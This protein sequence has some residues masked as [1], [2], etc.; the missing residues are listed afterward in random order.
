[1]L[2]FVEC[3]TVDIAFVLVNF[4]VN[5]TECL[6]HAR[7]TVFAGGQCCRSQF[8]R[9]PFSVVARRLALHVRN[10]PEVFLI[11]LAL[12]RASFGQGYPPPVITNQ[13]PG[14]IAACGTSANFT[15]GATGQ[16]PLSYQWMRNGEI[17]AGATTTFLTLPSLDAG[18]A[19]VYRVMVSNGGGSTISDGAVLQLLDPAAYP[20]SIGTAGNN[21]VLS[22]PDS[23]A[24]YIVQQ[25]PTLTAPV[26]WAPV[27]APPIPTGGSNQVTLP[28]PASTQFYRLVA[29]NHAGFGNLLAP[30]LTFTLPDTNQVIAAINWGDL[31][32]DGRPD[33]VV[34][35]T[36]PVAG[37]F[38]LWLY[39]NQGVP[40][41]FTTDS[42]APPQIIDSEAAAPPSALLFQDIDGGYISDGIRA[43]AQHRA[44]L[45]LGPRPEQ[46]IRSALRR[47]VEA[48]R[49]TG[50]DAALRREADASGL[51]DLR[52]NPSRPTD[53]Q[54]RGLMIGRLQRLERMGLTTNVGPSQ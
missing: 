25:A 2:H 18:A 46:E 9:G 7:N 3:L 11:W 10:E 27:S 47:E 16:P 34:A 8:M 33:V 48:A 37:G 43:R 6:A 32:G 20:L 4:E 14:Q 26:S 45:E 15:V 17:L 13:P 38:T 53:L 28:L 22:W 23:C 12:A 24:S 42:L 31:D 35:S 39:P 41:S 30:P 54:I 21:I 5:Y 40:G 19:G 52:P 50:L 29:A 51:V 49:W 36:S 1:M 44:T